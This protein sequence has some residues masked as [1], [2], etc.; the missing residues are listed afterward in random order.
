MDRNEFLKRSVRYLLY[1]ILAAIALATGS[2]ITA[3]QDCRSCPGNGIC[4]GENDCSTFLKK[5]NGT[6]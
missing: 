5:D 3:S 1:G 2:R 6:R 4:R